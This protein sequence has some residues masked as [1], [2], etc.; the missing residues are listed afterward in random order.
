MINSTEVGHDDRHRQGNDEHSAQWADSSYN[1]AGD[2]TGH[3]VSVPAQYS[4]H[5]KTIMNIEMHQRTYEMPLIKT[6]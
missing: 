1:L 6:K 5:D 3:H 4:G 2:R